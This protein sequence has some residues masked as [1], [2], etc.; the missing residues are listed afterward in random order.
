MVL[1]LFVV[2]VG[3]TGLSE[4]T[5]STKS[6]QN[7][8]P[9]EKF[10]IDVT[11]NR[12]TSG[13]STL[14]AGNWLQN[15]AVGNDSLKA[16]LQAHAAR[17]V[18]LMPVDGKT[19]W[20]I[21]NDATNAIPTFNSDGSVTITQNVDSTH[22]WPYVY[23]EEDIVVDLDATPYI[24]ISYGGDAAFNLG[25]YYNNNTDFNVSVGGE[26]IGSDFPAGDHTGTNAYCLNLAEATGLSG[27]ITLN[28]C[29]FYTVGAKNTKVILQDIGFVSS[30]GGC[31]QI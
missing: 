2:P 30:P 13:T 16:F 17:Y 11:A 21:N 22:Y 19:K 9:T 29:L 14:I 28:K 20:D 15:L 12:Y 23:T 18:D 5:G 8:A 1:S 10:S 4:N 24:Y 26:C 7:A 25:F 3:A 6:A 31:V 27:V